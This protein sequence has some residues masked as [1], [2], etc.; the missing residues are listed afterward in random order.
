MAKPKPPPFVVLCDTREQT[1]PPLPPGCVYE[2]KLLKEG[3]YST[4]ALEMIA[5]IERKSAT[6]FASTLSWGRERFER[7][8]ERLRAFR[9]KAI[10]VESDLSLVYR[11]TAMTP[12]SILG[13]IASLYARWDCPV[14]FAANE[15]GCGRL[16][17][18]I[19]L[20]WQR[21]IEA[22]VAQ[23]ALEAGSP[24]PGPDA[25]GLPPSVAEPTPHALA[26][27]TATADRVL[28]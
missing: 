19:L 4:P 13:S 20:R 21:R 6:D 22:E 26:E 15:A 16:M 17:A 28:P 11:C 12:A 24:H 25:A 8:L 14:L 5:R 27:L 1:P 7:E 23:S 10:V 9:W 3:D 18:G 2:R